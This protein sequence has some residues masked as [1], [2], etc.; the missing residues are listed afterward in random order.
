MRKK[1]VISPQAG[2]GNRFR[3]LCTAKV[4]GTL[5]GRDV[6]HFWTRDNV[7]S[8]K[9]H[10]NRMKLITPEYYFQFGISAFD[11]SRVDICYSEW[12][13]ND[14]WFPEQ[15]TAQRFLKCDQVVGWDRIREIAEFEGEVALVE[16][17]RELIFPPQMEFRSVLM[18]EVYRRDFVLNDRWQ[19]VWENLPSFDIGVHV[20]RGDLLAYF[21]EARLQIDQ[22]VARVKA[23]GGS[24]MILSDDSGFQNELRMRCNA[25]LGLEIAQSSVGPTDYDFIYF[26]LL[27]KCQTVYGT[28]GSSFAEQ[29]ALFGRRPYHDI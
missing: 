15:S 5:I 19:A 22:I 8:E 17:S 24:K 12:G 29:A 10:V 6:F 4:L 14:I 28:P 11:G 26:L 23:L 3:A 20:R 27:S 1:L 18:G 13:P 2:M 16:T 7:F 21:P 25:M 9:P